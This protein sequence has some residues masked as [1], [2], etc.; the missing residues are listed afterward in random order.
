MRNRILILLLLS[1]TLVGACH[2]PERLPE[3]TGDLE[4]RFAAAENLTKAGGA[5]DGDEFSEFVVILTDLDEKV[6]ATAKSGDPGVNFAGSQSSFTVTFVGLQ[7][8]YYRVYAYANYT[9]EAWQDTTIA[10][11]E[12][13][14]APAS[15]LNPFRVL[16]ALPNTGEL[17]VPGDKMLLTGTK[18]LFV[19]LDQN[20]AT[21]ELLRPVVRLNVLVRNNTTVGI[22]VTSLSFSNFNAS[23]SFLLPQR[24]ASGNLRFPQ[25]TTHGPLPVL[26]AETV[27]SDD[28]VKVEAGQSKTVYS[29]LLYENE[30]GIDYQMFAKILK[31]G[32]AD[33][34]ALETDGLRL[35]SY[36]DVAN[37]ADGD[38]KKV[39]LVNPMCRKST[40]NQPGR[41]FGY[42][43]SVPGIVSTQASFNFE[44]TYL[45]LA[46]TLRNTVN[47]DK[48]VLT[49]EKTA[50]GFVIRK[51]AANLL[52]DGVYLKLYGEGTTAVYDKDKYVVAPE[53][54]GRLFVLQ[55]NGSTGDK[56]LLYNVGETSLAFYSGSGRATYAS[57][58]WAFYEVD[59]QGSMLR[60]IDNDTHQVSPLTRMP[61]NQE[62]NIVMNVYQ[63]ITP[64]GFTVSV[65]NGTW[66]QDNTSSH[67]FK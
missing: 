38:T 5:A 45:E 29:K 18:D 41:F 13:L 14:M 31:E 24:D 17:P 25:N 48:Y 59:P 22:K 32:S 20:A 57:R 28:S 2:R 9:H 60:Q 27:P 6:V 67:L 23:K 42:D 21:V 40:G 56:Y 44:S 39:L 64:G 52:G 63:G 49:L 51:G 35:L 26:S 7:V 10:S 53:F 54:S 33:P 43:S 36:L 46:N 65:E 58:M 1:A 4:L 61:R 66:T 37:M 16:K 55:K 34:V 19:G 47:A 62:L 15:V 30:A 50:N 11:T 8:G 12:A 3:G